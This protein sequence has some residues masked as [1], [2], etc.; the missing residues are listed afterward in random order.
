[1]I[2]AIL[3]VLVILGLIFPKS[4]YIVVLDVS[5]L[6]FIIGLRSY[7]ATDYNNYWIE[8]N[9]ATLIRVSQ[10]DFPG[11]NL[12]MRI[13]QSIGLGFNQFIIVVAFLSLI[14]MVIGMLK[15]SKYVPFAFSLFLI[16]PFAHEAVQMRTF[17]ADAIIWYALPFLLI[18]YKDKYKNLYS[19]GCFFLLAC[20]ATTIHTLCWFFIMV[21]FIYLIFRSN[22]HYLLVIVSTITFML[23]IIKTNVLSNILTIISSSDKLDHWIEGSVGLGAVIFI[24][25]SIIIYILLWYS[26]NKIIENSV[27]DSLTHIQ[28][29]IQKFSAGIILIIPFLTYDITFN[30]LWRVFLGMLYLTSGEY[31]YSDHKLSK[32]KLLY[33]LI[34]V[35]LIAIMFILENEAEILRTLMG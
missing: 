27:S 31:L 5:I 9:N 4:K 12:L 34:I 18:D 1:M 35:L 7:L 19:K 15:V 23:V 26:S 28:L 3:S 30:R 16:Y 20:V 29:N 13:C 10:A 2:Y 21:A 22:R 17:L 8:Y 33:V 32:K 24:I 25:I 14:L 11:Y 6:G